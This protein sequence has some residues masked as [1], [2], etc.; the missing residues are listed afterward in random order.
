[1][2]INLP[3]QIILITGASSGIGKAMVKSFAAAGATI[4]IHYNSNKQA[5]E[6]LAKQAG[7]NSKSFQA[8]LSQPTD[9]EK[10]FSAVINHYGRLDVLINNAGIFE[11]SPISSE[12]WLEMWQRTM[13]TNLTSAALLCKFAIEHFLEKDGGK[14]INISSRAAFRGDTKDYLAYAASK[15]GMVALTK[16][17]ARAYGKNNI[18]AFSIAPG[19]VRTPMAEEFIEQNGEEEVLKEIALAKLTMPE[20]IAPTAVFLAS[21]HMDHATGSTIDINAGSYVR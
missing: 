10:L 3:N 17:I 13:D 11:F 8:N 18:K 14:I 7:N 16:S 21:G 5:A 2:K 15:G 20:D 6:E 4:A 19:F 12:N 1:M 9:A